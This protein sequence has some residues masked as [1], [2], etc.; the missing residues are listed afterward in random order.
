[1]GWR[2]RSLR[3]PIPAVEGIEWRGI[4]VRFMAGTAAVLLGACSSVFP[5]PSSGRSGAAEPAARVR[6]PVASRPSGDGVELWLLSDSYHTSLVLPL[7]WIEAHGFRTPPSVRGAPFV[8][9][10]WGDRVAYEQERWLTPGEIFRAL[11]LPSDAVIEIIAVEYDPRWVFPDQRV[12]R[13]VVA[14]E[15]GPALAAFLNHCLAPATG[16]SGWQ[17]IGNST[18]GRGSLILSPHDYQFP[19]LCNAWTAGALQTCGFQFGPQDRVFAG[20]L[21]R[22]C[23]AQGFERIP[24]LTRAE[25]EFLDNYLRQAGYDTDG[26]QT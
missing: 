12:F 6:Q 24:R 14:P 19:R 18:W 16:S 3:F 26:N 15:H 7:D 4:A 17:V 20:A 13:A 8:N 2:F 1:M 23:L 5:V 11:C 21:V 22:S 25:R 10:S 9:L